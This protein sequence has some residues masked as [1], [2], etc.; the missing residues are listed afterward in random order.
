LKLSGVGKNIQRKDA[1][2]QSFAKEDQTSLKDFLI[3]DSLRP[4][5]LCAFALETPDPEPIPYAR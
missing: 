5:H 1:T 4:L 3:L 2:A